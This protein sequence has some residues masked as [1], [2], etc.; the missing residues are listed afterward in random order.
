MIIVGLLALA[1]IAG[2]SSSVGAADPVTAQTEIARA[3]AKVGP[4]DAQKE[5]TLSVSL[6]PVSQQAISAFIAGLSDPQSPNLH[7]FLTPKEFTARFLDPAGRKLVAAFLRSKGLA[8]KDTGVGSII[9]A[10]GTAGQVAAAFGVT[11]SDYADATGKTFYANDRTPALPAALAPRI[12]AVLGLTNAT[13]AHSHAIEDT[14]PTRR[15]VAPNTATGCAGAT[16]LVASG[17]HTPNQF[18]TAYDFDTLY[19]AGF[20]GE[21]QTMALF[22]LSD[23]NMS[24]SNA[25]KACFG[26]STPVNRVNVDGGT[27]VDPDGQA[28]VNLDIDIIVGM[29]PNLPNLNVY[30]APN[31]GAGLVDAYQQIASDNTAQVISTSWGLCEFFNGS[32]LGT[33]ENTI[34][35]Q[36]A[37]QGQQIFAASGDSGSE[38]CSGVLSVDDPASQPY[39]TGVGGTTVNI[40][41]TSNAYLSETVWNHSGGGGGGGL[42]TVWARPAFQTGPGTTNPYTNGMREV[43][44]MSGPADPSTGF[45]VFTGGGWHKYGGTSAA[46]PFNAAGFALINQALLARFGSRIGFTNPY[47]YS[48]LTNH[49]NALHDVTVG[50]NC[51]Q[52]SGPCATAGNSYPATANYDLATGVGTLKVGAIANALA[53]PVGPAP[54]PAPRSGTAGGS[55]QNSPPAPRSTGPPAVTTPAPLPIPR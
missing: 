39:V 2:A 15:V 52:A 23:W 25:Y 29:L 6:A 37:T 45:P 38:D 55:T 22:E 35:S 36:M 10:T 12:A 41:N 50:N 26:L 20:R 8:V 7:K 3:E 34:F 33:S 32:A 30:V 48:L 43:P 54:A 53:P 49:P 16:N 42:S 9:N 40:N 1:Q 11:L 18:A 4:T 19:A 24:D 27:S 17:A 5:I 47:A 46:A 13:A 21:G 14:N 51:A 44:D 31:T 28:E